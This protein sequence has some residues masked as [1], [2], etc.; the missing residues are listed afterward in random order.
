MTTWMQYPPKFLSGDQRHQSRLQKLEFTVVQTGKDSRRI[1]LSH[2]T[3]SQQH[4]E[5]SISSSAAVGRVIVTE[6]AEI[7]LN[8]HHPKIE[9]DDIRFNFHWF[10]NFFCIS[11]GDV[12]SQL[13]I[14]FHKTGPYVTLIFETLTRRAYCNA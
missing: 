10:H 6:E 3:Q 14:F 12:G 9:T 1:E 11:F 8:K 7:Q 4:A 13:K 5:L 2:D